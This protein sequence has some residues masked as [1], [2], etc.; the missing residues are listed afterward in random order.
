MRLIFLAQG[1]MIV[2]FAYLCYWFLTLL[3]LDPIYR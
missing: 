1:T 2:F 3:G